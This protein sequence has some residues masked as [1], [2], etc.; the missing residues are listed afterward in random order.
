MTLN[1]MMVRMLRRC[2]RRQIQRIDHRQ[3]P[4]TRPRQML[5]KNRQ[6][7]IQN[8]MTHHIPCP[9]PER[10]Q[11]PESFHGSRT[12]PQMHAGERPPSDQRSHS[13][14]PAVRRRLNIDKQT[15]A[16]VRE[17]HAGKIAAKQ[18]STRLLGNRNGNTG[19]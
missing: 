14:H 9:H 7:K 6:V 15:P 2:E 11:L 10:L 13:V 4:Q 5:T 8:V 1:Q 19:W 16:K 3:F 12:R 17:T 18:L